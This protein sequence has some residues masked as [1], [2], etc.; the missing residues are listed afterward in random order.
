MKHLFYPLALT[1]LMT[2][3]AGMESAGDDSA[4]YEEKVMV[5]GSNIPRKKSSNDVPVASKEDTEKAMRTMN[6]PPNMS[7][8]H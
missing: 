8:S 5:T 7:A 1:V 3:C 4:G 2:G 6:L